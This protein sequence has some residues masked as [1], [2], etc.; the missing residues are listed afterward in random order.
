[1]PR[2][3]RINVSL[4][5]SFVAWLYEI[6][7]SILRDVLTR[8]RWCARKFSGYHAVAFNRQAHNMSHQCTPVG[9][10]MKAR[11]SNEEKVLSVM[12][13]GLLYRI[14][15]KR[16][17]WFAHLGSTLA[18]RRTAPSTAFK[19]LDPICR[20]YSPFTLQFLS[21][22]AVHRRPLFSPILDIVF[23]ETTCISD[24][25]LFSSS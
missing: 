7:G 8:G 13:S 3:S 23:L 24:S 16:V 4:R 22:H 25:W 17:P 9:S 15:A 2:A 12:I 19:S 6:E 20:P 18:A 11:V 1:V 10:R 14:R 5:L 21:F